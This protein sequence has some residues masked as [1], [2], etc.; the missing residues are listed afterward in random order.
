MIPI[1]IVGGRREERDSRLD[2][3]LAGRR[4]LET[5]DG[6]GESLKIEAVRKFLNHLALKFRPE[7]RVALVIREAQALTHVA[8]NALL[9]SLEELPEEIEFFLTTDRSA[10]L[11]ETVVSRCKVVNLDARL[12]EV[13]GEDEAEFVALFKL[14]GEGKYGSLIKLT[15]EW[16]KLGAEIRLEKLAAW[17]RQKSRSRPS[18]S[19][20]AALA[21]VLVAWREQK[22]QVNKQLSL[23]HLFFSLVQLVGKG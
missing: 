2:E 12:P 10:S 11:L 20:A 17:L 15:E 9:K 1:L 18:A 16:V 14:V 3:A 6:E 8:Q 21:A 4:V 5:L 13:T 23:E 7:D 22:L 19:R